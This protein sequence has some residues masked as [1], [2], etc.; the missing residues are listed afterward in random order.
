MLLKHNK[1]NLLVYF[2][3]KLNFYNIN[4]IVNQGLD[5]DIVSDSKHQKDITNKNALNF[6]KTCIKCE[7]KINCQLY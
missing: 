7:C 5:L 4:I 2:F 6:L 3:V 1:Y